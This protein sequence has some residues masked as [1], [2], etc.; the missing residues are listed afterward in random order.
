MSETAT[1][2]VRLSLPPPK[3]MRL[4]NPLV[5]RILATS[6]LGRHIQLQGMIE[7]TGRRSGRA[8][9]VPVCLHDV[10]GETLIFTERPW[11]LNFAGGAPVTVTHRGRVRHGR[12]VL[13][14]APPAQIGA[15]LRAALD[16]GATPFELGLKV[17]RGYHPTSDDLAAIHRGLIRVEFDD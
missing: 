15:A 16:N 17:T 6:A 12:A 7:F 11:R 5:R 14:D 1:A 2:N 3:L 9:R 8:V 13:L 4:V 10:D